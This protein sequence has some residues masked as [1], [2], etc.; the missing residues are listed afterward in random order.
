MENEITLRKITTGSLS[1]GGILNT[2][3]AKKFIT[4]IIDESVLKNNVRIRNMVG[5]VEEVDRLHIG[6][7]V[8]KAKAE[9][10]TN[11]SGDFV[12]VSGSAITLNTVAL[13][14]PWEI[15]WETMEDN[16]EGG[17]FEDTLMQ[18]IA[19]A[20]ANDLEE[21]AIQGDTES[22]DTYLALKDGWIKLYK[23]DSANDVDTS[24]FTTK[25]LNKNHFSKLLKGLPTKYRRNR[26]KLRFLCNPDDEQDYRSSLTGRDTNLGD[27]AI[28]GNDKLRTYGI[29]LVPVPY[30][31]QGT[32]ILTHFQNFIFGI[33]R[34]IRLEKDRDIFKGVNQFCFHTRVGFAVEKGEA[35]S[36]TDDVETATDF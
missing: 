35:V 16:V 8:T 30:I 17:N 11:A 31:P 3:Q 33:W 23:A 27:S 12:T 18:Q 2:Q 10:V 22:L 5:P 9:G 20:M 26:A 36:Y 21:L 24:A 13:I 29:E 32:V 1:G 34:K 28:V 6:T 4:F 19:A 25:S 7:R 14:T 15:T